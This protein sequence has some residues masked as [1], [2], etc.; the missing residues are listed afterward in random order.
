VLG[1]EGGGG[2]HC[3][4]FCCKAPGP[5]EFVVRHRGGPLPVKRAA[6]QDPPVLKSVPTFFFVG[7]AENAA[8]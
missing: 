1:G 5:Y 8:A 4:M 7:A 3:Q 2:E 6:Y